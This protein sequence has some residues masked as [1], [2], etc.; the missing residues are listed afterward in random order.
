MIWELEGV[1]FGCDAL[2]TKILDGN[3]HLIGFQYKAGKIGSSFSVTDA[4][5]AHTKLQKQLLAIGAIFAKVFK[6]TVIF[7]G[8]IL[9][10]AKRFAHIVWSDS[11]NLTIDSNDSG[12]YSIPGKGSTIINV[13]KQFFDITKPIQ[14]V[15][16]SVIS[17]AET[18]QWEL[19][20]H[21]LLAINTLEY[22]KHKINKD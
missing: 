20:E 15:T 12:E 4:K 9:F 10:L 13:H 7:D 17:M 22:W 18:K 19:S 11:I 21:L 5:D 8:Q 16:C 2:A 6:K 1:D 3:I 14:N